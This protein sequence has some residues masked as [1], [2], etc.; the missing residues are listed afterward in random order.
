[1]VVIP[2]MAVVHDHYLPVMAMMM[3]GAVMVALFIVNRDDRFVC[4]GSGGESAETENG[5]QQGE[6]VFHMRWVRRV[7]LSFI[8]FIQM[9][10]PSNFSPQE[11]NR[12]DFHRDRP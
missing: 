6:G 11:K 4:L 3:P 1:M 5:E 2:V 10:R 12:R 8:R 7:G 9:T